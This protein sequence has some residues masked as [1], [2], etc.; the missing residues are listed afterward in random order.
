MSGIVKYGSTQKMKGFSSQLEGVPTAQR[1]ILYKTGN[2]TKNQTGNHRS[3]I[4]EGVYKQ[5]GRKESSSL[6]QNVN[7]Y[8]RDGGSRRSPFCYH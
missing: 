8:R 7:K 4:T 2:H 1:D 5:Q 6:L 3:I